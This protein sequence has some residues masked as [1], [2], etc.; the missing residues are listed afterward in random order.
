M[1]W[2]ERQHNNQSREEEEREVQWF[3]WVGWALRWLWM[4]EQKHSR[5]NNQPTNQFE[6]KTIKFVLRFGEESAAKTQQ[7]AEREGLMWMHN[8]V[9]MLLYTYL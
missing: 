4:A 5:H 1:A 8:H 2:E 3:N 7:P 9:V 6:R